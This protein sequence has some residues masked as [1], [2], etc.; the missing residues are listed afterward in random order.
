MDP[1]N[2]PSFAI[3][4]NQVEEE[5]T[6]RTHPGFSGALCQAFAISPLQTGSRHQR[7]QNIFRG[8]GFHR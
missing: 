1:Q 7:Q 5:Q 6:R 4:V 3:G 2:R 8:F